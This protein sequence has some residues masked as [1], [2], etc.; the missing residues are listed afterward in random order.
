MTRQVLLAAMA[1]IIALFS[2]L[3]GSGIGQAYHLYPIASAVVMGLYALFPVQRTLVKGQVRSRE[4]FLALLVVL[5]FILWP[6]LKG[7]KTQGLEYSW[8]LMLPYVVGLIALS[9]KDVEAI[10]LACGIFGVVVLGARLGLG[11]F[12]NWNRNDIAMAGFTGMAL[13]TVV[14]WKTWGMKIFHKVLLVIITVMVL[15]LAVSA[16]VPP[17]AARPQSIAASRANAIIRFINI[18]PFALWV[19]YT[20]TPPT[21]QAGWGDIFRQIH[22][23]S[24]VALS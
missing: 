20:L 17:Q 16:S 3:A 11:I 12:G 7:Y 15:A 14:P 1:M 2:L 19:H 22:Q 23:F 8:L 21:A 18:L 9:S 5:I 10:G 24:V 6:M 13:C 4:F